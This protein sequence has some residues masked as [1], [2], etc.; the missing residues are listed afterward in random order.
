[1]NNKLSIQDLASVLAEKSGMDMK[2]ASAFI[3]TV[4]EIVEEY[5]AIDKSCEM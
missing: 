3:K 1:M 5:I 4:F 2:T